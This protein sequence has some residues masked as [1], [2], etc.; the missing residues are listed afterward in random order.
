M[1]NLAGMSVKE[2]QQLCAAAGI[3]TKGLRKAELVA[4]L[5]NQE[6]RDDNSAVVKTVRLEGQMVRR[7]LMTWKLNKRTS[8]WIRRTISKL[9]V[10]LK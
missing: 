7:E 8:Q 3:P 1:S 5:E 9:A 4:S 2:L 10:R 6:E